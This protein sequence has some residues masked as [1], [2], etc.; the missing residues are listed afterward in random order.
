MSFHFCYMTRL[1]V[2]CARKPLWPVLQFCEGLCMHWQLDVIFFAVC[3]KFA[4]FL[5]CLRHWS[6]VDHILPVKMCGTHLGVVVSVIFVGSV[7]H[8]LRC[9]SRTLGWTKGS[10]CLAWNG[11]VVTCMDSKWIV[12]LNCRLCPSCIWVPAYLA[13]CIR[14]WLGDSN[15]SWQ[16]T[17]QL[18][19]SQQLQR[20]RENSPCLRIQHWRHRQDLLRRNP[21]KRESRTLLIC[22]E[23]TRKTKEERDAGRDDDRSRSPRLRMQEASDHNDATDLLTSTTGLAVG[24]TSMVAALKGST[25]KLETLIKSTYTLQQD[26]CR[27]LEAVGAAVNNMARASESLAAGVN[28]NTSRVG[29]V[30][31]EY[32]KLKKHLDVGTGCIH[33]RRAQEKHQEPHGTRPSSAG[34]D[35]PAFRIDGQ[36]TRKYAEDCCEDR[37]GTGKS[38]RNH[39]LWSTSTA[40]GTSWYVAE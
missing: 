2:S 12:K 11:W 37:K 18:R 25:D 10:L 34:F 14:L 23:K 6:L 38:R 28:H 32:N 1:W 3:H 19:Q 33:G 26:L 39:G 40:H 13:K 31:G 35:D 36:T 15:N 8:L 22:M 29:A 16:R 27:S 9:A 7:N 17:C 24:I 30:V 21:R 20:Q 4:L 5:F